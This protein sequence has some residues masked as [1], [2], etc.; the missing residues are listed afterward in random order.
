MPRLSVALSCVLPC[1]CLVAT[2]FAG[3]YPPG[4]GTD[5]SSNGYLAAAERYL[6]EL[7][8]ADAGV[9]FERLGGTTATNWAVISN[10][11]IVANLK[12]SGGNTDHRGAVVAYRLGS[13]LD[14]PI[15]PVAVYRDVDL[16]I[17]GRRVVGQCALKEW[18]S[19][20]TQYYWTHDTFSDTDNADKRRLIAALRCDAA[21]P[22]GEDA[23]RYQAL[24]AFGHPQ[25]PGKRRVS[26]YGNARLHDAARDFS[27]MMVVDAL[28]GNEDRF[29]GGNLFF[30]SVTNAYA[31][32]GGSVAFDQARLFSL[33]NE[34]VFKGTSPDSTHAARDL[35]QYV[36]RFDAQMIDRLQELHDDETRLARVVDGSHDL[37]AFIR[38]GIDGVLAGYRSAVSRCGAEDAVF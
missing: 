37:V 2:A 31:I 28:L 29:P 30:R 38:A 13:A 15:Y 35:R 7:D 1:L 12:C 24:S 21:R 14:F 3:A 23:F 6:R 11:D 18:E 19:A 20:F 36:T 33:D 4:P 27:N 9:R 17:D 25:M 5:R 10:G 32:E 22:A 34:A 26:Y 16:H 8:L